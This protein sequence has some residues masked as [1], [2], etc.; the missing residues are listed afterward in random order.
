MSNRAEVVERV[1]AAAE[2]TPYAVTQTP[3]GF[4]VALD[5]VDAQWFGL[6]NKAGLRKAYIHHVKVKDDGAFTIT[7][8]SRA[9]TG[10]LP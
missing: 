4:D 5:I 8:E 7:D 9:S 2:G 10:W 3:G 1:R 6:F